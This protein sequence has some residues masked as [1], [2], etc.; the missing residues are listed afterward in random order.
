[1]WPLG[2][3]GRCNTGGVS[4]FCISYT[5]LQCYLLP[6]AVG[7]G[8]MVS[9]ICSCFP[10]ISRPGDRSSKSKMAVLF[11]KVLGLLANGATVTDDAGFIL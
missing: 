7:G 8:E 11:H 3:W 10:V 5:L 1:M 9:H 2:C 6:P 4:L